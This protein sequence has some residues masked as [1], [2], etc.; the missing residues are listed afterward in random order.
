MT[1]FFEKHQTKQNLDVSSERLSDFISYLSNEVDDANSSRKFLEAAWRE[2]H[3]RYEGIPR[4]D[5]RD[6]PVENAPNIEV[7]IGAIAAD[8]IYAQ[9]IDLIFSVTPLVTVRP[10]PK[11]L[12]DEEMLKDSKA[13]QTFI[14][15]LGTSPEVDLR[16]AAED[17]LLD[18]VQL[19][20]GVLYTPWVVKEKKT[21]TAKILSQGPRVRAVAIE[22]VIV[23]GGTWQTIDEMPFFG[24][25]FHYTE[26]QLKS[27]ARVNGWDISNFQPLGARNWVRSRR[28]ILARHNEG[29]ETKG[30]LYEVI[31]IYC[32]YDID[33]DGFD[34]DLLVVYNHTG[35]AIGKYTFNPMDRR[36]ATKMVYQRRPHMFY[37]L[38]ILEMIGPYEQELT[39]VHNYATLNMLLANS[40]VWAGDGSVPQNLKIW[41]GR[42]IT[43]LADKDSLRPLAMSDVYN[44]IW[45]EQ[46]MIVQLANQRIGLSEGVSPQSIPNRTP[47]IT[48]MSM[49]QQ[50]N[51]RFTPAFDSMKS[52]ICGALLQCLYRYQERLLA[53]DQ[54]AMSAIYQVMG[55][56]EGNRV[57]NLLSKEIFDEQIDVELTASSATVNREADRQNA[58][59][60]TNILVQYYQ[61]TLE[62]MSI[63]A[64]PQTPP[65][66]RTIAN[67][68]TN[69]AGEIIDRTI[70]TFDQVR[71]PR[72]FVIEV[73]DKMKELEES[74]GSNQVALQQLLTSLMQSGGQQQEPKQVGMMGGGE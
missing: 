5:T 28:E 17:A 55:Y 14:N 24:I 38:G 70:R 22:D 72:T 4:L 20:T 45:Q 30:K 50:I 16:N 69:A 53:G 34:E 21:K 13:L 66:V 67:R 59:M 71:D 40:R 8:T 7:T 43:D 33:D 10:K 37:G 61:R 57:I 19:G 27:I 44:S 41:A 48:T 46:M 36:P 47:G 73:D 1:N 2:C 3:L 18:D 58:M 39:D 64:N 68:I 42:V 26:Q 12:K 6:V 63:A 31:M 60:L 15:H 23:P 56:E 35:R 32:D 62:L 9:A 51:K 11:F 65:E 29:V 49:L 52:C 54:N 25:V 74:G